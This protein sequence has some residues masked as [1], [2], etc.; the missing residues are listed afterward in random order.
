MLKHLLVAAAVVAAIP[1]SADTLR[2]ATSADYPP[3]E[4]VN[5]AGEMIGFDI[6]VGQAICAKIKAECIWTNQAYDGLLPA[7]E[8]GQYDMIISAVS[9]TDE[10]KERIG[11]SSAYAQAPASFG[12]SGNGFGD[13][14]DRPGLQAALAG[15]AVGVQGSS[16]FEGLVGNHFP[17]AIIKT[18]ERADQ[19]VADL[20]I[21]RLDAALMETTSWASMSEANAGANL[22]TF[23]PQLDFS[24]YSELGEGIGLGF[25]K[26]DADLK[27]RVDEAIAELLADGTIAGISQTWFGFDA[28]P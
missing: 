4:S 14:A 7:L 10:R 8:A 11:F 21:G 17:D 2:V 25:S 18:Y 5:S 1:A 6:E 27:N 15:K 20:A 26:D 19:I 16:I 28:T 12:A 9:I 13:I 24:E 22:S 3:W 23:G